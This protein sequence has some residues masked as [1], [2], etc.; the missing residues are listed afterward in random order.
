MF[1]GLSWFLGRYTFRIQVCMNKNTRACPIV[2]HEP[3]SISLTSSESSEQHSST[4]EDECDSISEEELSLH[5]LVD[6]L[7]QDLSEIHYCLQQKQNTS[8]RKGPL[9]TSAPS[10]AASLGQALQLT[11][12][13]L[14]ACARLRKAVV[15]IIEKEEKSV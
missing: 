4:E 5:T 13:Q 7:Y 6:R 3:S 15:S 11:L 9:T 12:Q 2:E 10:L 14:T 1:F 8:T